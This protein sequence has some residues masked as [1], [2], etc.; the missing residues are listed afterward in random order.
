[1][2]CPLIT[3]L[4]GFVILKEAATRYKVAGISLAIFSIVILASGSAHEVLWSIFIASLYAFYLLIQRMIPEIDKLNMLGIQL[5]I[6]TIIMLPLFLY[7]QYSLPLEAGFWLNII[8]IALVFTVL[9]LFLSLYALIGID[10]STMGVLIYINPIVAF[11]VAFLYFTE[12]VTLIQALAYSMLFIAVLIFNG[13][14]IKR[15][16]KNSLS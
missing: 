7:H 13:D 11:T 5:I 16:F 1:M 3:A 14:F 4:G 10:S 2:V 9:P 12:Y 8:L 6:A 15:Y